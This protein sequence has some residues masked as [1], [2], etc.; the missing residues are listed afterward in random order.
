[1]IKSARKR[2]GAIKSVLTFDPAG[3]MSLARAVRIHA[4]R[5]PAHPALLFEGKSW[6][7]AELDREIDRRVAAFKAVDVEQGQTV[8]LLMSN[9]P[10]FL[11]FLLALNRMG[12]VA[13][14]INTNLSGAGLKHAVTIA[15]PVAALVGGELLA[16]YDA[17]ASEH[18]ELAEVKLLVEFEGEPVAGHNGVDLGALSGESTGIRPTDAPVKGTDLMGYIYTSGTTGLPKAGKILNARAVLAANGF[19]GWV[20]GMGPW[21][22]LYV[23]LPLFHSNGLLVGTSSALL[24]GSTVALARKFSAS[25]FWNDIHDTGAT[26]F[27]YIGEVCRYLVGQPRGPRDRGHKLR[28]MLGNGM[29]PEVWDEFVDRFSPGVVHEFYGA[30]E[31]NVIIINL[32]GKRGSVGKMPPLKKLN[33]ALLVKFDHDAQAPYRDAS[34]H[35]VRC[36]PGEAGE[37]LGRINTKMVTQRFDGYADDAATS[38]KVLRDVLEPGD[39]YFRSGDLLRRDKQGYYYFVDRIGDTFRWKGEN[40]STN[41]VGDAIQTLDSV[42]IANV[43]GVAIEGADGKAGMVTIVPAEG[44]SFDPAAF[45]AHVCKELPAYARP[46]FV[47]VADSVALTATFKLQKTQLV[48]DGYDPAGIADSLYYRDD[49]AGTYAPLDGAAFAE[50]SDGE[51]RF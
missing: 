9:R 49:D 26:V 23:C 10:E 37:L 5:R 33:N 25:R 3:D 15:E 19:G 1:M 46:A 18:S 4:R 17:A 45:Y 22:T 24:S 43:Y 44:A 28:A 2:A 34:G 47:R 11:F 30:T 42:E 21:D 20:L 40:V 35:C 41:E 7:Y 12:V 13:A 27:V 39:A 32:T 6:S 16:V 14:L 48:K 51:L 31:G 38:K 8:A 36:A 29:R 50:V